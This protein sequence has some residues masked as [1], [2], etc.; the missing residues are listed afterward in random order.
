MPSFAASTQPR[1]SS[2][3]TARPLCGSAR[4]TL[5]LRVSRGFAGGTWRGSRLRL[6]SRRAARDAPAD[7]MGPTDP[8]RNTDQ[9]V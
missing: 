9:G 7:G 1:A 6:G 8:S 5:T 4:C 2:I 3:G